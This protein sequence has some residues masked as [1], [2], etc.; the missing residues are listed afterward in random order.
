MRGRTVS[1]SNFV[2]SEPEGGATPCA[3]GRLK[4][5]QC[6]IDGSGD[7]AE[8]P[9]NA[10]HGSLFARRRQRLTRALF[11]KDNGRRRLAVRPRR[12]ELFG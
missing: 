12:E 4:L 9:M 3:E 5:D 8:A 10:L 6:S 7:S 2:E 1:V 11:G